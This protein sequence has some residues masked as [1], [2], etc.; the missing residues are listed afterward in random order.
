MHLKEEPF[1]YRQSSAS[2]HEQEYHSDEDDLES[3]ASP[4][5]N[6]ERGDSAKKGMKDKDKKDKPVATRRR[7]VQSCSECR[8]RKIKCDKK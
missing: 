4:S 8:R 6:G 1:P 5:G 3:H 2:E 7:V